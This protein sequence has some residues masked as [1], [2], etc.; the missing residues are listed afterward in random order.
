MNLTKAQAAR[1]GITSDSHGAKVKADKSY[2]DTLVQGL[3][4]S[5]YVLSGVRG[6]SEWLFHPVRKWRLDYAIPEHKIAVEING[7]TSHHR[8][9]RMEEDN[10]KLAA[11][12]MMGWRVFY[13][14]VDQM[15]RGTA[16]LWVASA[17]TPTQANEGR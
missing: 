10:A 3:I 7:W 16:A 5:V 8:R 12:V 17:I 9:G 13:A 1:L 14:S 4:E 2:G 6:V 15:K 11:A